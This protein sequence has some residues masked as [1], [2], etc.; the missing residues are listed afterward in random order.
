M[1]FRIINRYNFYN[2]ATKSKNLL[3]MASIVINPELNSTEN[4]SKTDKFSEHVRLL[5]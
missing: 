3:S 1:I 5:T 4:K 2:V